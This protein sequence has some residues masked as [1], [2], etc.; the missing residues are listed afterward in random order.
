MIEA[1]VKF[2]LKQRAVV[3][4]LSALLL[5]LG[6]W[7]AQQLP[8]DAV[9][10]ITNVQVQVNVT[11]P[12]LGAEEVERQLTFPL[13]IALAGLPKLEE[14][15]SISQFGL[16][17]IVLVFEEG[18]DLY[19]IRNLVAQRLEGAKEQLP[20]RVKAELGPVTTGL[21]EIYY[22]RLDNPNLSLMERRSLMDWV[23]RPALLSVPGLAEVNTWGGEARQVQVQLDPQKLQALG[24]SVPDVVK[25]ISESNENAGGAAISQGGEQQLVRS[26]GTAKGADDLKKIVLGAPE[27]VPVTLAQVAVITDA[28]LV[29]QGAMTANGQG[30]QVYAINLLLIGENGRIVVERTKEKLLAIEKSLPPGSKLL[31]FLDRAELIER[32]LQTAIKNLVEG[33][34]LVI[35]V[36]FLFLLQL[37]AGLIVSAVIPLAMLFAVIGMRVFH[38]SANLMSLGAIDFGLIVDGAV[39]IVENTVRRLV[40]A[41]HHSN[42]DLTE[43]ERQDVIY[44]AAAEVLKPSLAGIVIIMA[45]YLPILSLDGVEGKMFRPMGLTVLFA[46]TGALLLSLTLVPALCSL[47]LKARSEKR[48]P[49][50][51]QMER[52]YRPLL[53][54]TLRLPVVPVTLSVA[55]LAIAI[56]L[57]PRLGS[58]FMPQL[59]EGAI[60]VEAI[61]APSISLDEVVERAGV[62]ERFIQQKFP[63]EIKEVVTRIGRPEVA[64]DP[65]LINQTDILIDLNSP[66]QWKKAKSKA[67]L[68]EKVATELNKLPGMGVSLTQ[69]IQMRMGELLAG[70]GQRSDLGVQLF[71]PDPATLAS[72][73]DKLTRLIRSVPGAVDV[74]AETTQGLPQLQIALDRDTIARYG[75]RIAEVNATLAAAVG[76][77]VATTLSDGAT[78]VDVSVRLQERFR[79]TPEAIGEIPISLV[80][81]GSIPL[82]QLA[83]ISSIEGPVQ[84]SRENGQRRIT[85]QSNVRGRDLGSLAEDVKKKLNAE[86][87]AP[88]GY[89]LEFAG[90]FEQL[91]SGRARLAIVTP[92][93]FLLIFSLLYTTFG[94]LKQAALVFTGIPLAVTGGVFALYLRGL[95]FS[96]SAG[97]GFIAL[98]GIAVLNGV[99]LVS[100]INDL[101]REGKPTREAVVEGAVAR[102]R[103]VL[104]TASVA[105][106]GFLPMAVASGA[107]AEVQKPLATVVIGGLISAT[108][109]TLVVLPTL[110]ARFEKQ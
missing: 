72:E 81:G 88:V 36:L 108:L 47:F 6:I 46:L 93:A 59:D 53:E 67:E 21:G 103:P 22:A 34:V 48:H 82:R 91:Q 42:R 24:F 84:I 104:M 10:D 38:V 75:V 16:S 49:V 85:V 109:L 62:A 107:G 110:Y 94:S 98:A 41:R 5:G 7:N 19:F 92:L 68:V 63:D 23:V 95:P 29:R 65:M 60:A 33:G 96:I 73:A 50:L 11:A 102:L 43:P 97:I 37:R 56:W 99:V 12:S 52:A 58:E 30:E 4:I 86:Y 70:V 51:H 45:A 89:R 80:G 25:A 18:T 90:T 77:Q 2:S 32:T 35:I 39:I 20:P 87:K 27:G 17:Q 79:S 66:S 1:I 74:R 3:L 69:P 9:P 78:R 55:L 83:R 61:Y 106:I 14:T 15:R 101:H 28:P 64:T 71:G 8:I 76:G 44:R 54:G 26:I 40:E 13:E 57:F 31:G 100:F 105:G